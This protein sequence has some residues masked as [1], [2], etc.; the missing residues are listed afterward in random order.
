M[1]YLKFKD[2]LMNFLN[3]STQTYLK[4]KF[5]SCYLLLEQTGYP[6]VILILSL[7]FK[8]KIFFMA[9]HQNLKTPKD[10]DT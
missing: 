6:T 5:N 7:K 3:R 9:S 8:S 4:H 2:F 1:C 10:I